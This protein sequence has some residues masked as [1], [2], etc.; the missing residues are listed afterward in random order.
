MAMLGREV[1]SSGERWHETKTTSF[2]AGK[3]TMEDQTR[4]RQNHQTDPLA[5]ALDRS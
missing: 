2:A 5:F 1:E 3:A 4:E